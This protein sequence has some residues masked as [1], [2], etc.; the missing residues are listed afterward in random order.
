VD[1][2]FDAAFDHDMVEPGNFIE[3]ADD[4]A[5]GGNG[6]AM[7]EGEIVIDVDIVTASEAELDGVGTDVAGA[8][9]DEDTHDFF[10]QAVGRVI[11]YFFVGQIIQYG[12]ERWH[13]RVGCF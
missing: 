13:G 9:G 2:G 1:N 6:L 8:A 11:G 5:V 3:I 7:A 4:E 12:V 10:S